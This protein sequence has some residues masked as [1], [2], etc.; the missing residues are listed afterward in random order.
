VPAA[1]DRLRILHL[2]DR[3]SA[4][5]GA[6]WHLLGVLAHLAR[7]AELVLA[8]GRDDGTATAPCP[9]ARVPA[10]AES[11]SAPLGPELA[12]LLDDFAPDVLHVHNVMSPTAL[13][14]A[15]ERG[16]MMTV[17]DHRSFCP[18]RGKLTATGEVCRVAM[19]RAACAPCFDDHAY[20]QRL[21]ALT[22][23][24]LDALRGMRAITVLSAY[25]RRELAEVGLEPSRVA[26][27]P[28]FA[29]GLDAAAVASG[30]PCVLF[31]GRLV[32]A[33]G[34][35]D[36]V[37]AWRAAEVALPLVFAGSGSERQ[38]LEAAG[39][40]VLG[41]VPHEAVSGLY[42]RAR[43]LL[44]PS[45]WQEPF[46][47]VGLEAL[48]LGVPVVAWD[49]GGVREWA[50][51]DVAPYGDVDALATRLRR[52]LADATQPAAPPPG[53]DQASLM[54]ALWDVYRR[55]A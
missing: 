47:I 48:T 29:F 16:A 31:C 49:S 54:A 41:W 52:A 7:E 43:A 38:A 46:G 8:V 27:V 37:A 24:R 17:Q 30:P 51:D 26:V 44:L 14:W 25:M 34:V 28:P 18:G 22:R 35:W 32:A 50:G 11:H 33:K 36:A 21:E 19:S 45:R 9:V 40:E 15:A 3:L 10:L 53:F 4:R 39:F 1:H 5:G 6:D 55:V 20:V 23:A 13:A 2:T 42:R 12:R